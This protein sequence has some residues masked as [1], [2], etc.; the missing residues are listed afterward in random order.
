MPIFRL[1]ALYDLLDGMRPLRFFFR[2]RLGRFTAEHRPKIQEY[3][4]EPYCGIAPQEKHVPAPAQKPRSED[5][6]RAKDERD[7]FALCHAHD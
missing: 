4:T 7:P 3:D 5:Q 1:F 2:G 6:P